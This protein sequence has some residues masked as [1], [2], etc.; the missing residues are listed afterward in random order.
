MQKS[1][2]V[3]FFLLALS[4]NISA[5]NEAEK[6]Y[7]KA[8]SLYNAAAIN[9]TQFKYAEAIK[10]T[11]ELIELARKRSNNLDLYYG[12]NML[13]EIYDK[14]NDTVQPTYYSRQALTYALKTN[15][16]AVISGAY[17]NLASTLGRSTAQIDEAFDLYQKALVLDRKRND[18]VFLN[19]ALNIAEIYFMRN[20]YDKMPP[21]LREAEASL[22]RSIEEFDDPQIYL[23]MLWSDYYYNKGD[24]KRSLSLSK[25]AFESIQQ[26]SLSYLGVD[27]YP[28]YVQR[29]EDNEDYK[30]SNEVN[31]ALIEHL[32]KEHASSE[33][34]KIFRAA[35]ESQQQELA[36]VKKENLFKEE[37]ALSTLKNR[38]M[39]LV[40][41]GLVVV[42]LIIFLILLYR[43]VKIRQRL[44]NNLKSK[45]K[46]LAEAKVIAEKS[47]EDKTRFFSTVSHEIRTPLYGVTGVISLLEARDDRKLTKQEMKS[48]KFSSQHLLGIINDL[49][50]ISKLETQEFILQQK[51]FDLPHLMRE[52]YSA[53]AQGEIN[54]NNTFHLSIGENVPQFVTG[55]PKRLSQILFN[56]LGNANKFTHNGDI[57]IHVNSS[58]IA[59]SW[60]EICFAVEDTGEGI[61]EEAKDK[62][63]QEFNQ[64]DGDHKLSIQAIGTGLGLTIVA[65]ILK[66]MDSKIELQTEKG[67]G[68]TFSFK[69]NLKEVSVKE[70]L[71]IEKENTEDYFERFKD[72]LK[73]K[74]VLVVD[75][76]PINL[77]V[78]KK[79]L[80]T[81]GINVTTVKS[82]EEAVEHSLLKRYDLVLTDINMP[83]GIDG[84]ETATRIMNIYPD[85][86]IIAL[87]A[88]ETIDLKKKV[89]EYGLC[90]LVTKPYNQKDLFN[91]LIA[92]L[93]PTNQ[94][95]V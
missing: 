25:K 18:S 88:A 44:I 75:D 94:V 73:D 81:K 86:P 92:C 68:S 11:S 29:L 87:S 15:N 1:L 85:M 32:K 69:L 50:D 61:D 52:I 20:Q 80:M 10:G 35:V 9:I 4:Q 12:Y 38:K 93:K 53:F 13:S 71:K 79:I 77:M 40:I 91:T 59:E 60:N 56:L 49:L 14:I 34:H 5:Q 45:N 33:Q 74:E 2:C 62:I 3:V 82:G 95:L 54:H 64:V 26:D 28:R 83:A 6:Y 30:T 57:T 16:E 72:L 23:D 63:F 65:K 17:N 84:F 51:S 46:Q 47:V 89:K 70:V 48:L 78:T 37:I 24:V 7:K 36:R 55:D 21:Y 76:N 19:P 67:K 41:F 42:F 8:D 39:L 31:K 22:S 43:N 27:Y 58:P 66:K 90:A